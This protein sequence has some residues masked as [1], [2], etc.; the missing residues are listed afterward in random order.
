MSIATRL[1]IVTALVVAAGLIGTIW[2]ILR[3]LVKRGGVIEHFDLA[4]LGLGEAL[5]GGLG[6]SATLVLF[7]TEFCA[8]CPGVERAYLELLA[9]RPWAKLVK[10]DLTNR[11]DLAVRFHVLQTPT[12]FVLDGRSAVA[13]RIGGAPKLPAVEAMLDELAAGASNSYSI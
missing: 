12:T 11:N 7:S 6:E 5:A 10:V 13:A 9:T 8:I 1:L 3:G 2:L 4:S